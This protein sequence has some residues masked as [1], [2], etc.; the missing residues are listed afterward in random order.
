MGNRIYG[1]DDCLAVCPWNKFAQPGRDAKL[2]PRE[3]LAAPMLAE[4]AALDDAGFRARFAGSPIKRIGR[5]RFVRNVMIAVGNSG[6]GSLLGA[7]MRGADDADP[8]VAEAAGWAAER[9]RAC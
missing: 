9:L 2:R 7:A 5:D 1:C 6:D 3:D 8:V 4:L